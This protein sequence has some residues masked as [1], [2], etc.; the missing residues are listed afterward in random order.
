MY[1]SQCGTKL[2]EGTA[3][4]PSCGASTN[5]A[6]SSKQAEGTKPELIPTP[7]FMPRKTTDGAGI[8]A[9]IVGAIG[10]VLAWLVALLGY[11][12]GGVALACALSSRSKLGSSATSTL[13]IVFGSVTLAFSL[14][15]SI[16]GVILMLM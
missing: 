3:F 4:C 8:A 15:N 6:V 7:L 12:C 1:C 2:E 5:A 14:I 9:V 13:G 10:L 16:L 11:I